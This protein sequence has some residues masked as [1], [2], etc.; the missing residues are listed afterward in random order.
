MERKYTERLSQARVS[1]I[2]QIINAELF[3]QEAFLQ[4]GLTARMLA[5]RNGISMQDISAVC[6]EYFGG[7]FAMLIQR[8]RVRKVCR[9]LSSREYERVSCENISRQSLYN[10]FRRQKGMTPEGYRQKNLNNNEKNSNTDD[11]STVDG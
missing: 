4:Q 9:M 2:C 1:R 3:Q 10:A 11:S 6:A 5:A 8:L 7:S